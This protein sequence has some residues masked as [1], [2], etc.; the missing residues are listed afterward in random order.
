MV[1]VLSRSKT[2]YL[3]ISEK[4]PN[5]KLKE[6]K[7]YKGDKCTKLTEVELQGTSRAEIL[8]FTRSLCSEYDFGVPNV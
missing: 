4:R 8:Y 1:S 6:G 7:C 2:A 3:A 5:S